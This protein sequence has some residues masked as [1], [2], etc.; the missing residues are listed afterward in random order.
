MAAGLTYC[1]T[2]VVRAVA[3]RIGAV[4][5]PGGRKMHAIATPTL[6]G[7]ALVFR[8]LGRPAPASLRVSRRGGRKMPAIATPTLG[9]LALFF[10]FIGGLALSSLL[11]PRLFVSSEAA[12]IAIGASLMVGIGIV[13][14]LKGLSAPVKL[15][16]QILAATTMTFGGVQVLFFWLPSFGPLN[17]GVISLAPELGIPITVLVVLV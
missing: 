1:L 11:F 13:D 8:F 16:G 17:E 12:G 15:A 5:R 9:G 6:G 14:D 10:G 4:D 7:L 2:P 3:L